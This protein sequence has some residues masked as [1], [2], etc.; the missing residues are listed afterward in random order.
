LSKNLDD[1]AEENI[2]KMRDSSM[3]NYRS[4]SRSNYKKDFSSNVWMPV[5]GASP[6]RYEETMSALSPNSA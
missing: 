5:E 6:I 2:Y 3:T 1:E 4:P